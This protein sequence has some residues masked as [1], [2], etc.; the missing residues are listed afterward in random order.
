MHSTPSP[1]VALITSGGQVLSYAL[2]IQLIQSPSKSNNDMIT[3]DLVPSIHMSELELEED[4]G[5][6]SDSDES[7][8]EG[9][10]ESKLNLIELFKGSLM[11]TQRAPSRTWKSF[12]RGRSP[13]P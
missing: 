10:G 7:E 13:D 6:G 4:F 8:S 5:S 9:E 3:Q 2:L 12:K 1:A 11:P